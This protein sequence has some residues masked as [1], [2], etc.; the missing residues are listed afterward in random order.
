MRTPWASA[1]G[2]YPEFSTTAS[3]EKSPPPFAS[4]RTSGIAR[5]ASLG[6]TA[7]RK[8]KW[9]AAIGSTCSDGGLSR[10]PGRQPP[11][12]TLPS[13]GWSNG[14]NGT[15]ALPP[16]TWSFQYSHRASPSPGGE[17]LPFGGSGS[18]GLVQ[19]RD[20]SPTTPN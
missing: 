8:A 10:T 3:M 13:V 5:R 6:I 2:R 1:V 4:T 19:R 20:E 15:K 7:F 18:S 16:M 9:A 14:L 12:W 17:G 11:T